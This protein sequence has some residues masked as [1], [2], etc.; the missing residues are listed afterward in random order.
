MVNRAQIDNSTL[1]SSHVLK[2]ASD[3]NRKHILI[4]NDLNLLWDDSKISESDKIVY[5]N[6]QKN[7]KFN[8]TMYEVELP[9]KIDHPVIGD[10]YISCKSRFS[11]LEK[12]LASNRDLFASYN[13]IIKDQ[14]SK[15]IIEKVSNFE[16]NIGDVHYLS[17][18][19]VIRGDKQ[20]SKVRIVFDASA[21]TSGPSLN[22]CLFSGPSLTT[23]IYSILLHFHAKRIAL[24]ADIEKVFLNIA[25]AEKRRDFVRFIWYKDLFDLDNNHLKKC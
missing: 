2:A 24:I 3:F 17:H 11:A 19:P 10:N 8:G 7:I 22:K 6:F 25:L 4:K 13:N 9:F 16:S 5:E 20:T 18:R 21:C 14:L 15:G 12:K 1:L 23:S